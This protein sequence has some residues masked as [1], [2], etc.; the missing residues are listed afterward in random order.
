ME[1]SFHRCVGGVE[2]SV[3][4][5]FKEIDDYNFEQFLISIWM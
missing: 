5:F 4:G 2:W 1:T 3:K